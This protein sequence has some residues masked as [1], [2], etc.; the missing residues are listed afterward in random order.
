MKDV[1]SQLADLAVLQSRTDADE[2]KI[3]AAAI[4]RH[5]ELKGKLDAVGL[6]ARRGD[7]GAAHTYQAMVGEMGQLNIVIGKAR[8]ALQ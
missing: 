1:K 4:A 5:D 3:L 7:E 2:K 6:A 8:A